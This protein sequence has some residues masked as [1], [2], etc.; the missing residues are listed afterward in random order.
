MLLC[1]EEEAWNDTAEF[2]RGRRG[3]DVHRF[4]DDQRTTAQH[5]SPS[6][7]SL[8]ALEPNMSRLPE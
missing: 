2:E 1:E 3:S 7:A 8:P 5:P 4:R 6:S